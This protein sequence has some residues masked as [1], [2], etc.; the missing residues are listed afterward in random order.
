M[1]QPYI[2]FSLLAAFSFAISQLA[3]K[4]ASKHEISNPWVLLVYSEVCF[5]PFLFL[6]PILFKINF[7]STGLIYIFLYAL[8]FF[9]GNIFYTRALYKLDIS[10][11]APFFQLQTA[12][13]AIMA[14]VFLKEHFPLLNYFY[15]TVMIVGSILIS[16]DENMSL[17]SYFSLGVLLIVVQQVLH[18]SSNIFAGFGV[19]LISQFTFLFWGDLLAA[20]LVLTI[21]PFL[22]FSQLKVKFEQLKPLLLSGLFSTIGA[23]SMFTAFQTNV[24]ISS[25]LGLLSAPL[26]FILSVFASIFKPDLL[27]HHTKKVYL[28]R[29]IGILLILLGAIKL[30]TS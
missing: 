12:L 28:V 3:S 20:L 26:V 27:E 1:I 25:V 21:I 6:Y 16:L 5:L 4:F 18:A 19:K 24:T 8:A 10:S 23:T 14:F 17:K 29:G 15:I 7:P 30:S 2:L 11:I 9:I 22:G 13:I